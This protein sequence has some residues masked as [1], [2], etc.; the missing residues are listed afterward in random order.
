MQ[1][2]VVFMK[3]TRLSVLHAIW[4]MMGA[5][6]VY[7]L[8]GSLNSDLLSLLG[9]IPF[10]NLLFGLPGVVLLLLSLAFPKK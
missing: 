2:G 6:L 1:F 3:Q 8:R 10:G 5:L 4:S 7:M 9:D